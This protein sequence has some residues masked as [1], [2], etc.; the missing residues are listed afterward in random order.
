MVCKG[1]EKKSVQE[2]I[3]THTCA[4]ARTHTHTHIYIIKAKIIFSFSNIYL[5]KDRY[6]ESF[7][8]GLVGKESSCNARDMGSIPWSGRS[9]RAGHGKPLQYSC[10][11]NPMERGA[12]WATVHNVTKIQMWLSMHMCIH[13]HTHTNILLFW[14]VIS[15]SLSFWTWNH[16]VYEVLCFLLRFSPFQK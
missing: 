2:I 16:I 5:N 1:E 11:E 13:T 6:L 10:L 8:S 4:R 15:F 12:Q 3:H 14:C 7:P 9:P